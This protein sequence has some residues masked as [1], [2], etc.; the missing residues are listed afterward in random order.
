MSYQDFLAKV[1]A[2]RHRTPAEIDPVAQ[3]RVWLGSQA[4]MHGLVDTIGGLDTAIEMA[5][6]KANIPAAEN[7]TVVSYPARRSIVDLLLQ[8]RSQED[9]LDVKLRAVF[10]D[11]PFRAWM[12]GGFLRMMP[13]W[14]TVK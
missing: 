8:R 5:K 12:E 7:V 9:V 2:A 3:G 11:M 14:I 6:K 13:Y 4:K 1:A 10:R